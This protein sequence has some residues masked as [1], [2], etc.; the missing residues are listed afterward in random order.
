VSFGAAHV[1]W[2]SEDGDDDATEPEIP[3]PAAW[4]AQRGIGL[5]QLMGNW[6]AAFEWFLNLGDEARRAANAL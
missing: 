4:A 3:W 5:D 6:A 1:A 2:L